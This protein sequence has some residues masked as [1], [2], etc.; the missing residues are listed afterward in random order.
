M[1]YRKAATRATMAPSPPRATVFRL[2]APGSV[3]VGVGG[4]VLLV[5]SLLA[6]VVAGA[7]VVAAADV[8]S[9][10]VVGASVASMDGAVVA[11]A[12][13]VVASASV[14]AAGAEEAAVVS[15]PRGGTLRE[16]PAPAQSSEAAATVA[17]ISAGEHSDWTQGMREDTKA[18]A[19]QMQAKSVGEHPVDCKLSRAQERAHWGIDS[20]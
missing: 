1:I 20:S 8:S 19:L 17:S 4:A 12:S 15:V 7:S 10:D 11:S 9:A 13:V 18:V 5:V 3:P 2:A 14:V 6:A 16:T